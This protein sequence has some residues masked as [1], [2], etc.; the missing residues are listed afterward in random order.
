MHPVRH[1]MISHYYSS[2]ISLLWTFL[3]VSQMRHLVEE[4]ASCWWLWPQMDDCGWFPVAKCGWVWVG[5]GGFGYIWIGVGGCVGFAW[6]KKMMSI[7]RWPEKV[8]KPNHQPP[9]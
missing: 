3:Q 4:G 2:A 7:E 5:V 1:M 6:L 8:A 9:T